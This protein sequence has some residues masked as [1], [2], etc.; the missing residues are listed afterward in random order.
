V[1]ALER[2]RDKL[3]LHRAAVLRAGLGG[4]LTI[5]WRK[6]HPQTEPSSELLK[7]IL[8]ERRRHW[9]EKELRKFKEKGRQP[10]KNWKTKYKEPAEPKTANLPVLPLGWCW[11]SV[12]Q[13]ASKVVD[14]VHKKPN[15]VSAGVPFVTVKNLTAGPGISFEKLNYVTAE[16]HV[17][18][19]QR[20]D[21]QRGD[22]LISKDGTLG[23]VRVVETDIEF[24][25]F[26]SV[27]LVK[28]VIREMSDFLGL[29]LSSPQVQA[30][31]V[32]KGSGLVHIHLE[33]LR[34]DCVPLAPFAEQQEIIELVEDQ[35]SIIDHLESDL[36]SKLKTAQALRQ[37]ILRQAFWGKL[38]PQDP[39]DEPANELLRQIAAEREQRAREVIVAGR[40]NG[41]KPRH[42]GKSR[43]ENAHI[44]T[45][46]TDE[47]QHGRIADR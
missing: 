18:F 28:P 44:K 19:I 3:K 32:P 9:E 43:G 14:G 4:A 24:S 31:M 6:Q 13:I 22:I 30:Q 15:Y 16:D 26:V 45:L 23:V 33:D 12:E 34:E 29:V 42:V 17:Q 8:A 1:A 5:E 25:I 27:A 7:R 2:A 46:K 39:T 36:D 40:L 41:Q 37:S 35:I 38:V 11:A 10:P 20:A 47:T 21:P